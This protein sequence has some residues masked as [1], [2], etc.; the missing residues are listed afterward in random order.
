MSYINI[1]NITHSTDMDGMSSA[2]LL[3]HNYRIPLKNIMFISYDEKRFDYTIKKIGNM[4][5]KSDVFI[6]SDYMANKRQANAI[7]RVVMRL[8]KDS[9][10]VIWLDHHPWSDETFRLISK[11]CDIIIAGENRY[12]CGAQIVYDVLCEKDRYGDSITKLAHTAD[13]GLTS[14]TNETWL[15]RIASAVRYSNN[16]EDI[17][18]ADMSLRRVVKAVSMKDTKN[19]YVKKIADRFVSQSRKGTKRLLSNLATINVNGVKI[20]AGF[21]KK[22]QTQEVC[23]KIL[24]RFKADIAIYIDV[25]E[26]RVHMRSKGRIYCSRLAVLYGGGGHPYASGYLFSK[27]DMRDNSRKSREL[28]IEKIRKGAEKCY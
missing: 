2:A 3:V 23:T 22:L 7:K 5:A 17:E 13:F 21:G 6:F 19:N 11:Y 1:Y 26:R 20:M 16:I 24:K 8:K 10:I 14:K 15:R 27:S 28:M 4:R 9:N 12:M 25:N 18:K